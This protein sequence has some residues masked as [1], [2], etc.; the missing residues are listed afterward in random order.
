MLIKPAKTR[1]ITVTEQRRLRLSGSRGTRD[2]AGL[3]QLLPNLTLLGGPAIISGRK[4]IAVDQLA[5]PIQLAPTPEERRGGADQAEGRTWSAHRSREWPGERSWDWVCAAS[6]NV[7]LPLPAD[8][9]GPGTFQPTHSFSSNRHAEWSFHRQPPHRSTQRKTKTRT[10]TQPDSPAWSLLF[11]ALAPGCPLLDDRGALTKQIKEAN[12]IVEV[13]GAYVPL[14]P[15]G[16]TFKGLC[17][18]HDDHRPSFDVD[19][20]RQRY[21]CWSCGKSGDVFD[22]IMEH[23]RVDF[24]EALELLARRAGITLEKNAKSA[25]NPERA[26]MLELVRWSAEQ[27]Q[28]CLLESP[29]AE[30]AR[31]YLGERQLTSETIRRFGLGFAPPAGDWLVRKATQAGLSFELLEKVGLIARRQE[32]DGYYDRFRDRVMF[33]IRDVRGQA[34][35]F[36]GRI[37]PSS[38]LSARAPKYY[39]SSETP[40]F[41]KSEMLY[42]LDQARQAGTTA[43][44]LAVVEGYTDVLMAHQVGVPQVVA[45]MGTALNARHVR[46][47]RRF[48][49]RVVLVFD[50]DAGG[51]TGVDRALELFVSQ[52]VDLAVATLPEG[53]DPCDLLVNQGPEPFRKA[54]ENS[55]NVL[56][57]KLDR[58]LASKSY[59]GI[60]GQR[61][62]VDAVLGIIVQ[63]PWDQDIAGQVK[64]QLVVNR[65]AQRLGLRETQSEKKIWDRMHELRARAQ[66]RPNV[67]QDEDETEEDRRSAKA[68]PRE[69]EL[70]EVLLADPLLVPMAA[71]EVAPGDI[72]HPG[73]R[74]LLQGLYTLRAAGQSPDLDQLRA[75]LDNPRLAQAAQRLREVGRL[76]PAPR[77]WLEGLLSEFRRCRAEPVKQ[78]LQNQLH[79][80]SDH[81]EAV[82]L[83]RQL[84]Q[85]TV[86]LDPGTPDVAG[87]GS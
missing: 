28:Q 51:D 9:K 41:S 82:E 22:F 62:A 18:F 79:A 54:L 70:L 73:L 25:P 2:S 36:G 3:F 74:Q 27:F 83:L 75:R 23:D 30:P 64:R 11:S 86:S 52:E 38:P 17:P 66:R 55:V 26:L 80:A 46:N 8:G 76:N 20:R 67:A 37:L 5:K 65:L 85:R 78:Q 1:E 32:G 77:A 69:R 72:E 53:M 15:V 42:G 35:G 84:Q 16:P 34:M 59:Q 45:T 68:A 19:P 43:G 71:A 58:V 4:P 57:F 56:D 39:N 24:R 29:L 12:D 31:R 61:R 21:K 50:A 6:L 13:V 48:A 60:E 14:R 81:T 44:Y 7:L 63:A 40:L 87:A 47:L 49:P 33:P 10:R